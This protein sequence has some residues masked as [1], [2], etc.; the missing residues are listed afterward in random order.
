MRVESI[1]GHVQQSGTT[2]DEPQSER[3]QLSVQSE[4]GRHQRLGENC[5]PYLTLSKESKFA[6][7]IQR[8][9]ATAGEGGRGWG[10]AASDAMGRGMC[11]T[12]VGGKV[13]RAAQPKYWGFLECLREAL[14][15]TS[16]DAS[17][18]RVRHQ[19][20][21]TGTWRVGF[22]AEEQEFECGQRTV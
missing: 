21:T 12:A 18:S 16:H 19:I 13:G 14:A 6:R 4:F 1:S 10:E 2:K 17:V 20:G 8:F 7:E 3:R 11:Q 15:H 9:G 5:L 22:D